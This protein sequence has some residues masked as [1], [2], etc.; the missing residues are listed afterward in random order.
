LVWCVLE[1]SWVFLREVERM[2]EVF[3]SEFLVI[4]ILLW[5]EGD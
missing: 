4:V 5:L 2:W 3:R 1:C